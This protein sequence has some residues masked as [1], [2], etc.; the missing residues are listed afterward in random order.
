LESDL[1]SDVDQSIYIFGLER[2]GSIIISN[3]SSWS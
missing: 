1:E 2:T 3:C